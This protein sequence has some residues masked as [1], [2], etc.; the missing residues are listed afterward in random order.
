MADFVIKP[1]AGVSNKLILQTQ[2]ATDVLT[3]SDSG[4]TINSPTLVTPALGTVATGNLSN[5]AITGVSHTTSVVD[6]AGQNWDGV[7]YTDP[8]AVGS[9]PTAKIYPDGTVVGSTVHGNYTKYPNGDLECSYRSTSQ[10]ISN[11][12][13]GG[14]YYSPSLTFTFPVE[15]I[16]VPPVFNHFQHRNSSSNTDIGSW[17]TFSSAGT[18]CTNT[19]SPALY[20]IGGTSSSKGAVGYEASGRWK[21]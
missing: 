6:T 17:F 4:V 21:A 13:G 20:I 10:L 15:F 2:D 1:G 19:T 8:D 3:T 7:S 14:H 12:S 16:A 18:V 9:S 5:T 11:T